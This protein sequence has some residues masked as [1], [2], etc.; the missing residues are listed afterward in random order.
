MHLITPLVSGIANAENGSAKITRRGTTVLATLYSSFEGDSFSSASLDSSDRVILDDYGRAVV[1]V[2]EVCDVEV[3]DGSGTLQVSFTAGVSAAAVEVRSEAF[4]GRHYDASESS[5]VNQPTTLAAVLNLW[6]TVRGNPDWRI[7]AAQLPFIVVTDPAY[8]AEGDGVADDSVPILA[9]IAAAGVEGGIVFFPAGTYRVTEALVIPNAESITFLGSGRTATVLTIDA[10]ASSLIEGEGGSELTIVDMALRAEQATT[11]ALIE[12]D[13]SSV[14]PS[15]EL[16]QCALGGTHCNGD[17]IHNDQNALLRVTETT[18]Q[19]GD[20][21]SRA[22]ACNAGLSA[23]SFIVN[24]SFSA[25]PAAYTA[26]AIVYGNNLFLRGCRFITTSV[27][28]GTCTAVKFSQTAV[29]GAVLD[30]DFGAGSLAGTAA[31]IGMD[32]GSYASTATFVETGNK[33]PLQT[34]FSSPTSFKAYLYTPHADCVNVLLHSRAERSIVIVDN[35]GT[36]DIPTDQYGTVI[37]KST[38]TAADL[39]GARPP[40]GATGRVLFYHPSGGAG[41]VELTTGFFPTTT[42]VTA[43]LETY[44]FDYVCAQVNATL[45][46]MVFVNGFAFGSGA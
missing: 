43:N 40:H 32:L 12:L 23:S 14:V 44:G 36:V 17:L 15:L 28:S 22:I 18:F 11:T 3:F 5:G 7:S 6:Q 31:V 42:V 2:A 9:A 21:A 46:M 27:T 13:G 25:F 41:N 29:N 38:N 26:N 20:A 34:Q 33:F 45:R 39:Q 24:C 19:L 1:Y 4:T 35:N 37:V 8:G 16:R 30:C 10:A